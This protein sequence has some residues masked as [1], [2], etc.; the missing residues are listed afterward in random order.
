MKFSIV[1]E[2]ANAGD[3][4]FSIDSGETG[5]TFAI[6]GDVS[7][8]TALRMLAE[9]LNTRPEFQPVSEL[10]PGASRSI[11]NVKQAKR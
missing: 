7:P 5:G 6:P 11:H 1:R 10:P 9:W 3:C 2:H 8:F 4:L